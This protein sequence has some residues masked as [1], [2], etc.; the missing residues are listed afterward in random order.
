MP[1]LDGY[2]ATRSIRQNP[3]KRNIRI[4][5]LT[6]SAISGDRERCIAAG[7]DSYLAKPV[8]SHDLQRSIFEQ[9]ELLDSLNE[10][11]S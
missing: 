2:E 6:A 1:R 3:A 7:M 5:A 11:G 8:R 4:I 9:V 10:I